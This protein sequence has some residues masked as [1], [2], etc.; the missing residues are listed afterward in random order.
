MGHAAVAIHGRRALRQRVPRRIAEGRPAQLPPSQSRREGQAQVGA[1]WHPEGE[2][3]LLGAIRRNTR[4]ARAPIRELSETST[5][6]T[7][8]RFDP[9]VPR[10]LDCRSDCGRIRTGN[11]R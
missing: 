4:Q 8:R 11:R 1:R 7:D 9:P 5:S 10:R 6:R 3:V 2:S